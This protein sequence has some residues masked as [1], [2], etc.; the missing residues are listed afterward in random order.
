MKIIEAMK[1]VKANKEKITDL[2]A[3]ISTSCATLSFEHPLY[4]DTKAKIAEWAQS[5]NVLSQENIRLLVSIARTNLAT[6]T[7]IELGDKRVTKSLAEWVWRR[8]EY[9]AID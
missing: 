3:K 8:R 6:Y 5:C 2:Q 1:K 4:P 9:A 7:T